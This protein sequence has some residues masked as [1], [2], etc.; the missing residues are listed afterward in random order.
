[1]T[2]QPYPDYVNAP[3]FRW[4]GQSGA[5]YVRPVFFDSDPAQ[6][7]TV[8]FPVDNMLHNRIITGVSIMTLERCKK[9]PF[10]AVNYDVLTVAQVAQ[11]LV[12]LRGNVEGDDFV[13]E[14][15]A[16]SMFCDDANGNNGNMLKTRFRFLTENS[17]LIKTGS[18]AIAAPYV[19]PFIFHFDNK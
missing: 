11:F 7:D 12:S 14:N 18:L 17:F 5:L 3:A 8:N 19:I 16:C 1:M 15:V 10:N 13:F 4:F 9:I 6:M 2:G